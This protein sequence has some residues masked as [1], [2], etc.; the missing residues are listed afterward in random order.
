MAELEIWQIM[1]LTWDTNPWIISDVLF[2]LCALCLYI[3]LGKHFS[4]IP[5]ETKENKRGGTLFVRIYIA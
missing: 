4:D 3:D 2:K 1:E 5:Q